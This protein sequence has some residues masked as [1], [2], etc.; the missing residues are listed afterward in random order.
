MRQKVSRCL[1]AGV[2]L[3]SLAAPLRAQVHGVGE[4]KAWQP[5]KTPA[6][7]E[8]LLALKALAT[9][10]G[11]GNLDTLDDSPFGRQLA[12]PWIKEL[13]FY[14]VEDWPEHISK[15]AEA[16]R[17][18][19]RQAVLAREKELVAALAQPQHGFNQGDLHAAVAQMARFGRICGDA[20][21][22]ESIQRVFD[23]ANAPTLDKARAMAQMFMLLQQID[24]AG[25]KE[26]GI[27][28]GHEDPSITS[29]L[30]LHSAP[31]AHS[32]LYPPVPQAF[33]GGPL[34]LD[35]Y[36]I[37]L[38]FEI[39]GVIQ[40][41]RTRHSFAEDI[42]IYFKDEKSKEFAKKNNLLPELL[43]ERQV[44]SDVLSPL[45]RLS[46]LLRPRLR[47]Q[48]IVPASQYDQRMSEQT[49]K[50][51]AAQVITQ[52]ESHWLS[53][54]DRFR[55]L[56]LIAMGAP[57][58]LGFGPY[59]LQQPWMIGAIF[60]LWVGLWLSSAHSKS[61]GLSLGRWAVRR[62]LN[63]FLRRHR[64]ILRNVPGMLDVQIDTSYSLHPGRQ[65]PDIAPY[66][67]QPFLYFKIDDKASFQAVAES[68]RRAVPEIQ[69]FE[70]Y[71][72][73]S[74]DWHHISWRSQVSPEGLE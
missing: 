47:L 23:M 3:L 70:I 63:R 54:G 21:I 72:V 24:I 46:L 28:Q 48:G 8:Q 4:I 43:A 68:L 74:D 52:H 66:P 44:F 41:E 29:G 56:A 7:S 15:A 9:L 12:T 25:E 37:E 34:A 5:F 6:S 32:V 13:N 33:P 45:E 64:A 36:D 58:L 65:E 30:S 60:S 19:I 18:V 1:T 35:D 10:P 38:L 67:E 31:D 61:V 73:K 51:N 55:G 69:R 27:V 11:L 49:A 39:P 20:A 26:K 62:E 17:P 16:S 14:K 42:T 40:L 57:F 71:I 50:Y 22:S 59:L 2:L 53:L